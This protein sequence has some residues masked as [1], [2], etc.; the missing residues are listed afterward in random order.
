M[1]LHLILFAILIVG[2]VLLAWY[3]GDALLNFFERRRQTKQQ[4]RRQRTTRAL[5]VRETVLNTLL[6]VETRRDQIEGQIAEALSL[7]R[8]VTENGRALTAHKAATAVLDD[9]E[10]VVLSRE[11]LFHDYLD[12]ACLQSETIES[13]EKEVA[14]LREAVEMNQ[15]MAAQSASAH[16]LASVQQAQQ[17]RVQIDQR[18]HQLGRG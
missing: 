17:K 16:L 3:K 2:P 18:L 8:Q 12:T 6:Q 1:F 9:L 5:P 10:N 4:R 11:S 7:Y 14:L 15:D 13:M